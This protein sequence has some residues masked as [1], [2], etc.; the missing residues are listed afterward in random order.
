MIVC[1]DDYGLRPDIDAAILDLCQRSRLSAVSCMVSLQRCEPALLKQLF[2]LPV[3]IDVGLHLCFTREGVPWSA[4]AQEAMAA[5][6]CYRTLLNRALTGR[7]DASTLQR[8]IEIQHRLF[9]EKT[10]RP[11]AH[12]D[13]HLHAHQLPGIREALLQFVLSLPAHERPYVRNTALPLK[14]QL[15]HRLP[16]AKAFVIGRFGKTW[17]QKLARAGLP[18]NNG[19]VG[20]YD[21]RKWHEFP[22]YVRRFVTCLAG[23]RNG[24]LVVH[25]GRDENWRKQEYTTLREFTFPGGPP[26]R[27]D[28]MARHKDG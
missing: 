27:F 7:L 3:G 1:A 2:L 14:S 8:Q 28:N 9:V 26:N 23:D 13:G 12:I 10:G 20:I 24:M 17:H 5:A 25:P 22:R 18:T 4:G 19:F 16:I 11:P 21:F 15:R 6:P